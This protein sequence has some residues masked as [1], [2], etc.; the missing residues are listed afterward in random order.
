MCNNLLQRSIGKVPGNS[1][2]LQTYHTK[3]TPISG[4]YTAMGKKR[5]ISFT[6]D[7]Q[8]SLSIL[9][10][11]SFTTWAFRAL[12]LLL[13]VSRTMLRQARATLLIVPLFSFV[14]SLFYYFSSG[15]TIRSS[16]WTL[17]Q[18]SS[19]VSAFAPISVQ[20]YDTPPSGPAPPQ[21][22]NGPPTT[23]F[24]GATCLSFKVRR[25]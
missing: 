21:V 9:L 20:C 12:E 6:S 14:L 18:Q 17:W 2:A 24:R 11:R 23:R 7:I 22:L 8:Y 15:G 3:P 13:R 19:N 16:L 1:D 4:C 25:H 10:P 5:R